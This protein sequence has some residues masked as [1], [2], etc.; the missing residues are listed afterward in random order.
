MEF[1]SEEEMDDVTILLK[2]A[3][4]RY[5]TVEVN[6]GDED[7]DLNGTTKITKEIFEGTQDKTENAEV[8]LENLAKTMKNSRGQTEKCTS[9]GHN[10]LF[11]GEE[12]Y[13]SIDRSLPTASTCGTEKSR[14]VILNISPK[15]YAKKKD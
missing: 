2:E 8:F 7:I 15:K 11:D 3:K 6:F 14:E 12:E 10:A 4:K 9:K 1:D 5:Q 13:E